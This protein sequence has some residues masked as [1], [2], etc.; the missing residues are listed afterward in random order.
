M[1]VYMYSDDLCL[2]MESIAGR[3]NI[4]KDEPMNKH[5]TFKIG[6]NADYLVTPSTIEQ[7][8]ELVTLFNNENVPYYVIG[9]GSNLLVSD[10]GIRGVVIKLYDRYSGYE[11]LH[12]EVMSAADKANVIYIKVQAGMSLVKLGK[13]AADNSLT[14]FEFASGIPGSIGGGVMM[15]AGAYGGELKDVIV[16]A[17]VMDKTGNIYELTKDELNMGYRT[18]VIA[19]KNL[20]VLEAV[21]AL[22]PGDKKSVKEK[23]SEL[24]ASRVGKQPLEYPSAGSTFKRPAGNFAGKLIQEAGLKGACVGGAMVSEKHAGFVVNTGNATAKDVITLT[25]MVCDKVYLES[26]VRLELEVKKMGF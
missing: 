6:G 5:T 25:D 24:A 9:N 7:I 20:I 11:F 23:M 19:E 12:D 22:T 10:D 13:I 26:G 15:N 21:I 17:T 1:D 2:R 4:F 16:K 3:E 8:K 18:S 14:G